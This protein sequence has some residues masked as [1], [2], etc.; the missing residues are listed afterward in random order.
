MVDTS[1]EAIS[2]AFS[3]FMTGN[4][5][6]VIVKVMVWLLI[7]AA[8]GIICL[9]LYLFIIF[10][11]KVK[12]IRVRG[13]GSEETKYAVGKITSDWARKTKKGEWQFLLS[14]K[15]IAPIESQHIYQGNK[16]F[17]YDIDGE[18][19]TG[20]IQCA[21]GNFAINPIPFSVRRKAELELQQLEQDFSK[22]DSWEANKI[23][24]Y[25]LMGAAMVIILAGFV[26]WLAFKKTDSIVPALNTFSA[27]AKDFNTI[28]G[29]G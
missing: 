22:M 9:G 21:D 10:K 28:P 18:Y 17:I 23:F 5:G 25:T 16:V 24:I 15:K 7:I 14:R 13:S 1:P 27:A 19:V 11:Y 4:V 29:R 8:F 26:L 20:K 6:E 3:G 12:I 2:A